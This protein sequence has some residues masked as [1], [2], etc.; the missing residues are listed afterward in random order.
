MS[1]FHLSW[2]MSF[3]TLT[4]IVS[5]SLTLT[6]PEKQK[7]KKKKKENPNSSANPQP[8]GSIIVF[9]ISVKNNNILDFQAKWK[10]IKEGYG[11]SKHSHMHLA[12]F[13]KCR[14]CILCGIPSPE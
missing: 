14:R 12:A 5:F 1:T 6:S 10:K 4:H 2:T 13:Y 11:I 8:N 9:T 3:P 7:E